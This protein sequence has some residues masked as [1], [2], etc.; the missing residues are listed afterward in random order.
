MTTV[1]VQIP[2][3]RHLGDGV[4]ASF[5][6]GF[7]V[8][9]PANL[10]VTVAGVAQTL[11]TDFTVAGANLVFVTAPA[12]DAEILFQRETPIGQPIEFQTQATMTPKAVE[13]ALNDRALVDQEIGD[14]AARAMT[15]PIGEPG[16]ELP[17]VAARAGRPA[18]YDAEGQ[19]AVAPFTTVEF[20]ESV[21]A[22]A[23][24]ADQAE[25]AAEQ[26]EAA[27]IAAQAAAFEASQQ[28]NDDGFF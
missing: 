8:P 10:R 21:A 14:K 23:L 9:T 2:A 11:T 19:A 18:V 28:S 15:A 26:A 7:A 16:L 27:R 13:R 12:D 24:A 5:V 1:A 25:E 3:T 4:T 20:V 22:S 6:I 17:P